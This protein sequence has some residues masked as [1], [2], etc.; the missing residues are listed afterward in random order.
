MSYEENHSG[1]LEGCTGILAG[2]L[3]HHEAW[4]QYQL[5]KSRNYSYNY[6]HSYSYRR[7]DGNNKLVILQLD[8]SQPPNPAS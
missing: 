1:N 7:E 3:S 8:I 6:S 5:S 4:Q 2:K